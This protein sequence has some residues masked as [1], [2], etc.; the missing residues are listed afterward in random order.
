MYY[1]V[2]LTDRGSESEA[3]DTTVGSFS[4]KTPIKQLKIGSVREKETTVI[5]VQLY[6]DAAH[7]QPIGKL[8]SNVIILYPR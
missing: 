4:S 8:I 5:M 2:S 6:K 3:H 7:T 1:D